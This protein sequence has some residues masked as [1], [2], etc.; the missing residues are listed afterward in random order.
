MI[1]H[2]DFKVAGVSDPAR[3]AE[4]ALQSSRTLKV[5]GCNPV[6]DSGGN[7][8]LDVYLRVSGPEIDLAAV[9]KRLVEAGFQLRPP[10]SADEPTDSDSS[11]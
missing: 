2:A 8:A 1:S 10:P 5:L 4:L 7:L 3:V 6:E 11:L 9:R